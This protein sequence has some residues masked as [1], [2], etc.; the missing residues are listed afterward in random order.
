M[1]CYKI[2]EGNL[3]LFFENIV[4]LVL[5]I[6][7]KY[8]IKFIDDY[9]HIEYLSVLLITVIFIAYSFIIEYDFLK[10]FRSF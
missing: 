1:V 7:F 5:K 10:K 2:K 8:K 9:R 3:L 4:N 6:L